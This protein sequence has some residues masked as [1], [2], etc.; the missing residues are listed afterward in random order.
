[1]TTGIEQLKAASNRVTEIVNSF[2]NQEQPDVVAERKEELSQLKKDE[3]IDLIVELEKPKTEKGIRVE[4]VVKA[5]L[6]DPE[7]AIYSYNQIA[8]FV[9]QVLPDSKTSGKSV[10][11][12]ASKKKEDWAIVPRKKLDL[13]SIDLSALV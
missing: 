9:H 6:E 13:S 4:D 2:Q 12:Y 7:C 10:A 11:S 8:D 3:L 1:M 5:I